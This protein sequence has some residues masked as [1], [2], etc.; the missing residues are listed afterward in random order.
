MG[1]LFSNLGNFEIKEIDAGYRLECEN[2]IEEAVRLIRQFSGS[3][4]VITGAGIS[5]HALP[6]FRSNNHNGLWEALSIPNYSK[7]KFYEDPKIAWKLI[8][9][10]RNLQLQNDLK[11]SLAHKVLHELVQKHV[12]SSIITQNVDSL[13]TFKG[14]NDKIFE[15]HGAV[16]DYGFCEKCKQKKLVDHIRVLQTCEAPLCDVCQS[17]LMPSVKFFQDKIDEKVRKGA[18]NEIQKCDVLFLVGTHCEVD[19]VLSFAE[20]AKQNG[21]ILIEVNTETT[22]AT[23]FMDVVL[24]GKSD[25]IFRQIYQELYPNENINDL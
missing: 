24:R 9:N 7:E 22:R 23:P 19:P 11:P 18:Y 4:C 25:D 6:T 8:A 12:V 15:L 2:T 17:V 20:V 1:L 5:S 16:D 3:V 13:H 10:I 14:F 21:T